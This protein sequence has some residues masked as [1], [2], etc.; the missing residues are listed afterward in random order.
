MNKGKYVFSQITDFLPQQ[1]FIKMAA[2]V[3]D[4]TGGWSLSYWNHLLVLMYGQ[5]DGCNS[6]R[7]LIDV[8]KA[9]SKKSFHL[10]IGS[11]PPSLTTTSRANANRDYHL[12]EAFAHFMVELARKCRTDSVFI[13]PGIFYAFDSTTIDMCLSLFEWATFRSTKAGIKIHTQFDIR[14]QASKDFIITDARVHDVN[15]MDWIEYAPQACYIFDRG[16]FD[17]ARLWHINSIN[18]FFIIREKGR[19]MYEILEGDDLTDG[20]GNVLRDQT[21]RFA[22]S[23]NLAKYPSE[24]RRIV[25][26]A[27][28]PGRTFTFYTNNF[29]LSATGIARLYKNRWQVESFFKW[30]KQHLRVKHFWG[31]TENAVRIQIY[32]AIITYCLVFIIEHDL[33]LGKSVF[34]VLRILGSSLLTKD[35]IKHLFESA[36]EDPAESDGQLAMNF[37]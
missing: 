3:N 5:L 26:Y 15:A 16:Y 10:G 14:T 31:N 32:T 24:L 23:S 11:L 35:P 2:D 25:Y 33:Q 9:H 20:V 4:R 21:I 37:V 27:E 18:S 28:E 17:L 30:I 22:G 8:L 19:R 7:E 1:E 12:F 29:N 13:I 34:E 6:I 36:P